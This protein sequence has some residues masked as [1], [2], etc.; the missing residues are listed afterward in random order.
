MKSDNG[1]RVFKIALLKE[2]KKNDYLWKLDAQNE[3]HGIQDNFQNKI[4]T[5]RKPDFQILSKG[6]GENYPPKQTYAVSL[7]C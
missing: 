5:K 2:N 6:K 1:R 4:I 7:A 3:L